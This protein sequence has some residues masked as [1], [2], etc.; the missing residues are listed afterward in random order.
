LELNFYPFYNLITQSI[1]L[2]KKIRE[3]G[4]EKTFLL[5][6]L[7][8]TKFPRHSEIYIDSSIL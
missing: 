2:V 7:I 1:R 4:E 8:G 6:L 3:E 5:N